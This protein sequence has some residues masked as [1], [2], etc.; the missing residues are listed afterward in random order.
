MADYVGRSRRRR[1][2]SSKIF[3]ANKIT[4]YVFFGLIGFIF[5]V[6]ILFLWY[7]RDLPTPGKLVSADLSQSTRIL[8][9]N[10]IVLYD[11]YSGQNRTYVSLSKIPKYLQEGTISIEDKDF[12]KNQGYSITGYIRSILN[13]FLFRGLSGGSTITQQLIK[14]TLLT[15]ERTIPRKI[16]ELFW[17]LK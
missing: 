7:G 2:A 10:G 13:L 3:L 12:Y 14:E 17:R 5:L 4:R 6:I 15:S 9:K 8:D 11:I 1:S 16:K